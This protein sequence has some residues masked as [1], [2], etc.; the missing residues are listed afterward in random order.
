MDEMIFT[1][2]TGREYYVLCNGATASLYESGYVIFTGSLKQIVAL[3]LTFKRQGNVKS[4]IT[5]LQ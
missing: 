5:T 2:R 1:D 4:K 3:G